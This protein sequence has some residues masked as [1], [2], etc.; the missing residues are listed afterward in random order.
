MPGKPSPNQRRYIRD[1]WAC[2]EVARSENG[3]SRSFWAGVL[4]D[5]KAS[6]TDDGRGGP[7]CLAAA[8]AQRHGRRPVPGVSGNGRPLPSRSQEPEPHAH[9]MPFRRSRAEIERDRKA[10]IEA[11]VKR[12]RQEGIQNQETGAIEWKTIPV[13]R[14]EAE[15]M[16]PK[17]RED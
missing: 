5:L 3:D 9:G 1:A 11:V 17:P 14:E 15:Q 12:G 4:A 7:L 2:I 13:S 10:I 16:Y 8:I 6:W